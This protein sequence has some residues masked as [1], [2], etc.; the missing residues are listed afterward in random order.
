MANQSITVELDDETLRCLA[1]EGKPIEVLARLAHSAADGVR[2]RQPHRDQT[3]VSL[4]IEREEA[5]ALEARDVEAIE[6]QVDA[7]VK[8][9]RHRADVL[10]EA[11]RK[12]IEERLLDS[13]TADADL[14]FERA[15]AA[16]EHER[17]DQDAQIARTR[18]ARRR[19][20]TDLLAAER[21]A[22]DHDLVGERTT[23]DTLIV[24]LRE[25]NEK[26]LIATLRTQEM[27]DEL[28]ESEDRYRT[29]FELCPAGLYSCDSSGVIEEFNRHAAVLWGRS[30]AIQNAGQRFCG[31]FKLF[32][33]DGTFMP[34]DECPMASVIN[35][36][37]SEVRD[38]EVLIERPDGSRITVVA[39]ITAIKNHRGEITKVFNCFYDI[40]ERKQA[41]T[42]LADSLTTERQLS[43]FREMFIG[44]LGH[45]LRTPLASINMSTA[46]LLERGRLDEQDTKTV[47]RVVRSEQR[48]A[49]MI[50]QLLDLT[51][52]RLGGGL[53]LERAPIDLREVIQ[54]VVEEFDATIHVEVEGDLTGCWDAGRLSE[55]LSNLAGN[56]LRY[57]TRGTAVSVSA[58]P[59]ASGVVIEVKNQ[60]EPIPA[61]VLPFIFEP[62]R[63]A[64]QLEK[65]VTGNLGLGLYIAHQIVLSH[66]G[67]LDGRSADGTTSFV[68]RLPRSG[69]DSATS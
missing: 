23:M 50:A 64:R 60:G 54:G 16:L 4:R 66:G 43:E 2:N 19:S 45:D 29:L 15:R 27:T 25:A 35:G 6:K 69:T 44:I 53:P 49:Q 5:D 40:T 17:S 51:R 48:M 32:R 41:E 10:A 20:R 68:M 26:M 30:P 8:T 12:D 67:T 59:E 52:A 55:V 37:L 22:T 7:L 39:N 42:R 58:H 33:P 47:R 11:A 38:A 13:P 31:A 18:T 56:A 65:S 62:F 9:G 34:H 46:V 21:N 63:R 24:D 61:D 1:A 36:T 57:A 3:D 14:E 28:R